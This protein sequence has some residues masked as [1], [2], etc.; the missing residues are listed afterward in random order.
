[1]IIPVFSQETTSQLSKLFQLEGSWK[2]TLEDS[3]IITWTFEKVSL[4]EALYSKG[5]Q[6]NKNGKSA[7]QA[8]ALWTYDKNENKIIVLEVNS[9]N[10]IMIHKGF[11]NS[12]NLLY[13]K[14]SEN[15]FPEKV[16]QESFIQLENKD[17]MIIKF[18]SFE[19][20]NIT[21]TKYNFKRIR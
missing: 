8:D 10:I 13:L 14:W 11:F 5:V 9:I 2:T 3:S 1:M 17:E 6:T 16:I 18:K 7:Y 20:N 15:C 4:G 19:S 12:D 21:E